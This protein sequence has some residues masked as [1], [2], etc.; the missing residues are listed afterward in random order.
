MTGNQ[1]QAPD[2]DCPFC[3]PD[4]SRVFFEAELVFGLWDAFPVSDGHALLVTRRHIASWFDATPQ[5]RLALTEGVEAAQ[6]SIRQRH[7][8]DGFNIGMNVGAAA[9]QTVPHLH[10]HV[11]PRYAG[12]VLDPRGGVRHVIPS[13]ANYFVKEG[14]ERDTRRH[15]ITGGDDPL[16]PHITS[17]L[18]IANRADILVS[19]A[20]ES[21]VDRVFEHFRDLLARGGRLRLLTGDYL[22]ITEPNALMRLLDLEGDVERRVFETGSPQTPVQK[23]PAV[24]SFHPGRTLRSATPC[25]P[26]IS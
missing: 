7:T 4:G 15:L 14:R 18:A 6:H 16:L 22:G 3:R 8:P 2:S 21:G 17:H 9:G 12:D 24:R 25:I 11:I 5:E 19:F 13:L 1:N 23:M 20:L 10:L 26:Q